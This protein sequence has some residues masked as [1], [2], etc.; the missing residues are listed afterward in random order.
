MCS[1]IECVALPRS[2]GL[3]TAE[4]R[5]CVAFGLSTPF[6]A[7]AAHFR[8]SPARH[9]AVSHRS[10]TKRLSR[11]EARRIAANI[12]KLPGLL[13]PGRSDFAAVLRP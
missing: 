13:R 1:P 11:D 10:A 4:P 5:N 6:Q 8:F 7:Q 3:I 12:A 2:L 9:I